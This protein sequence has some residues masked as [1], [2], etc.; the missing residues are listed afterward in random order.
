MRRLK[1]QRLGELSPAQP[2]RWRAGP[3]DGGPAQSTL[4]RLRGICA[5]EINS[6][7]ANFATRRRIRQRS[8]AHQAAPASFATGR[9]IPSRPGENCAGPSPEKS[10]RPIRRRRGEFQLRRRIPRRP[11]SLDAA[12][13]NS[14][15]P[16]RIRWRPAEF[17]NVPANLTASRRIRRPGRRLLYTSL[18]VS[19]R[20][21]GILHRVRFVV[22][23][24]FDVAS[25]LCHTYG[26]ETGE[27]G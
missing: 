7:P 24:P 16:W 19:C 8:G 21:P 15:T 1:R 3:F 4:P 18:P 26:I 12:A 27:E 6:A 10:P 14:R 2:I 9:R 11:V 23:R 25:S 13:A 22:K 20:W 17:E 5:G